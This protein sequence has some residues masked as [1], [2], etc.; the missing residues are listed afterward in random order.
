MTFFQHGEQQQERLLS[1]NGGGNRHRGQFRVKLTS[2][3]AIVE[4]DDGEL[5]WDRVI[6]VFGRFIHVNCQDIA[7]TH[8]GRRRGRPFQLSE[9]LYV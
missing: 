8:D 5:P 3:D 6:Q 7:V 9:K 4:A 2:D 1:N